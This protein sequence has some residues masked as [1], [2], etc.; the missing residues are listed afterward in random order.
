MTDVLVV[1]LG[2]SAFW[3]V[4]LKSLGILCLC[5]SCSNDLQN[6]MFY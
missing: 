1:C 2:T 4:T 6:R 5:L 3:I